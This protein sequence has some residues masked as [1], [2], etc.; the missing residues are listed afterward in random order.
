IWKRRPL[1]R[2]RWAALAAGLALLVN[3]NLLVYNLA[4]GFDS[5]VYGWTVAD[6]YA[7]GQPLTATVYLV[8]MGMLMV[9]LARFLGGVVTPQQSGS[10]WLILLDPGLWPITLLATAGLVWQWRRGNTLPGLLLISLALLFP[11]VNF[12]FRP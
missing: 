3:L 4:T 9:G 2:T 1:L 10:E 6:D 5:F 12:D 7:Q 11:L 8:R